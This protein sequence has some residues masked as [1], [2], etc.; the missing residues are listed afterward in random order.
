MISANQ[1][2]GL[3]LTVESL[4]PYSSSILE[5]LL[6]FLSISPFPKSETKDLFEINNAISIFISLFSDVTYS[7]YQRIDICVCVGRKSNL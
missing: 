1:E 4:H 5:F 6:Y 2:T 7:L 3:S